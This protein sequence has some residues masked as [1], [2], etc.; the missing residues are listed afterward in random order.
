MNWEGRQ[1]DYRPFFPDRG[2]G[3][4]E[5]CLIFGLEIIQGRDFTEADWKTDVAKTLINEEAARVMQLT[6]PIGQK[7]EID[8]DYYTPEGPGR[9]TME[10]IGVFRDFHGIGLKQPIMPMILKAYRRGAKLFI[11]CAPHQERKRRRYS[12]SVQF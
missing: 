9:G 5:F 8:L 4:V 10:I 6:D 11:T 1:P 7:I 3:G 2:C 12:P